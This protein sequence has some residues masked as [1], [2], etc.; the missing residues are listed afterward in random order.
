VT[1]SYCSC[2][3]RFEEAETVGLLVLFHRAGRSTNVVMVV[4]DGQALTHSKGN[5]DNPALAAA[6]A[7][8]TTAATA[9]EHELEAV[10]P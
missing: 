6:A 9:T 4:P 5:R 1:L 7:P 2:V 10:A 3:F 8:T